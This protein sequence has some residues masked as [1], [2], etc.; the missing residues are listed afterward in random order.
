MLFCD[1]KLLALFTGRKDKISVQVFLHEAVL[2][3]QFSHQHILSLIGVSVHEDKPCALLPLMKNGDLK[4]YVT[5]H[6]DVSF[7]PFKIFCICPCPN[8][9]ILTS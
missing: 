9:I 2:M 6:Q 8:I 3:K 5:R 7:V 1:N 4:S